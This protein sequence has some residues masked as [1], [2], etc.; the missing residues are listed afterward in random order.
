MTNAP[1][2]FIAGFRFDEPIVK[3]DLHGTV[4]YSSASTGVRAP[5]AGSWRE[6]GQ[7]LALAARDI[8]AFHAD[9]DFG[10]LAAKRHDESGVPK[11]G[12]IGRAYASQWNLGGGARGS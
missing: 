4:A 8:S 6:H 7:A 12:F 2:V 3:S 10:K 5:G 11:T 1:P 9:I